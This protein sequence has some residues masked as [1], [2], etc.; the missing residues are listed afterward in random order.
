MLRTVRMSVYGAIPATTETRSLT[1]ALSAVRSARV[2]PVEVLDGRVVAT[3]AD[4]AV[5]EEERGPWPLALRPRDERRPSGEDRIL[6]DRLLRSSL[7]GRR[8]DGGLEDRGDHNYRLGLRVDP[9][10]SGGD[11]H[12]HDHDERQHDEAPPVE[13]RPRIPT[14]VG[15]KV[16]SCRPLKVHRDILGLG[17]ARRAPL[18]EPFLGTLLIPIPRR[19][20]YHRD[21]SGCQRLKLAR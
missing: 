1:S 9:G 18:K 16:V 12:H 11:Q 19:W 5:H 10:P 4:H 17:S 8:Q 6:Y 13:K 20:A 3:L 2:A 15:G 7:D 14:L 21:A